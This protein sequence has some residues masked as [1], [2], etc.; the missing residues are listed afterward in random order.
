MAVSIEIKERYK[1]L[2]QIVNE[3]SYK[4]FEKN[5]PEISDSEFD[6]LVKLL[7]AMEK[8]YP[9]LLTEKSPTLNIGHPPSKK[10]KKISHQKPLLSLNNAFDIA[11]LEAFD[12]KIHKILNLEIEQDIEYCAELKFDGLA[13]SL[14]YQDGY[15]Q[16]G[17]TRGDGYVGEDI[18]ENLRTLS[19]IPK[20][21]RNDIGLDD[22]EIRGE[23][24]MYKDDFRELNIQQEKNKLKP[25]ANPRNAAA[26]SLRQLDPLITLDRNLKFFAYSVNFFNENSVV[27]GSH[28]HQMEIIEKFGFTTTKYR[29]LI[30]GLKNLICFYEEVKAD[31]EAMPYEIDGVVYK[32]DNIL[33][34]NAL[35]FVS[36]APRFAIAHKFPPV[37][38]STTVVDIHVQ[39]GRTGSI[40][41][42]AI[43]EPVKVGGVII[44]K[45][46]LHNKYDLYRKDVRIGDVVEIRRAGDV[47][48]EV[49]RVNLDLRKKTSRKFHFPKNCPICGADVINDENESISR[50]TGGMNCSAQKIG[51]FANFVSRR[52]MNIDGLGNKLLDKLI[53]EK[54]L[55]TFYDLYTLEI[56]HLRGL[57]RMGLKSASNLIEAIKRSRNTTLARFIYALGIRNVG[58]GT[59]KILA[60]YFGS[61][62]SLM[63][64]KSSELQ[65]I[66]DIGPVVADSISDYFEIKKNREIVEKLSNLIIFEDKKNS[67][68]NNKTK[69]VVFTGSLKS[70]TRTE[71]SQLWEEKG[72]KV[73]RSINKEVDYIVVGEKA[74]GKYSQAR[75]LGITTLNEQ[76]FLVLIQKGI[77]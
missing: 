58:E 48:P 39:V 25:F 29:R 30:S 1:K 47:I 43:L 57:D 50:C 46:T 51:T 70:M 40:T 31:R 2:C 8:K 4:Y 28:Y 27:R 77:N 38:S 17:A 49:V 26:G 62:Q 45:A 37:W 75:R 71:A 6:H 61:M 19:S 60:E 13:V 69:N 65:T 18:T 41:P 14:T 68:S 76:E 32:V 73:S 56:S 7:K 54:I 67:P 12:K 42:V 44:S 9:S 63:I 15:F 55:D 33:M 11:D 52:A 66:N 21:I 72:G 53:D 34:Q 23:I 35:G 3:A 10:L 74:G 22:F 16:S 36:R 64:A 24:L 20:I 59:A 5:N